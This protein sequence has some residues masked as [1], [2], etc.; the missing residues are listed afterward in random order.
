M[1]RYL[2][3]IMEIMVIS[4]LSDHYLTVIFHYLDNYTFFVIFLLFFIIYHNLTCLKIEI[5]KY[6]TQAYESVR[7]RPAEYRYK[8]MHDDR[9]MEWPG[10]STTVCING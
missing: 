5:L 1:F 2:F 8:E 4:P 6:G 7:E 10:F 9:A 3:R